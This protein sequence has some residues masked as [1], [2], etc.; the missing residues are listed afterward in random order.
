MWQRSK[1]GG[2]VEAA[3][4]MEQEA[5]DT[6]KSV[7]NTAEGAVEKAEKKIAEKTA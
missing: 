4:E 6:V 7:A 3:K 1:E 2:S 5:V